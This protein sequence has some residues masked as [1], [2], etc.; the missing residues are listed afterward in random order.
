MFR[1]TIFFRDGAVGE[2]PEECAGNALR[3]PVGESRR[4]SFAL[5]NGQSGA[6]LKKDGT[7]WVVPRKPPA[8][9]LRRRRLR[10]ISDEGVFYFPGTFAMKKRHCKVKM[11]K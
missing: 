11:K 6:I 3:E 7:I 8:V 5:Q 10:P 4:V 9:K 2:S 1:Q